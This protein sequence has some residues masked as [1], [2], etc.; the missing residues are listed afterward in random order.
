MWNLQG[1]CFACSTSSWCFSFYISYKCFFCKLTSC[2]LGRQ[3]SLPS[4]YLQVWQKR[5]YL[6]LQF[7]SRM[8]RFR[9]LFVS[10]EWRCFP[11]PSHPPRTALYHHTSTVSIRPCVDNI[12]CSFRYKSWG[13]SSSQWKQ[14]IMWVMYNVIIM[15]FSFCMAQWLYLSSDGMSVTGACAMSAFLRWPVLVGMPLCCGSFDLVL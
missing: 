3:W 9:A 8:L 10:S 11:A 14:K 12:F 5:L 6:M 13:E 15:S 4:S 1:G 2:G 7:R